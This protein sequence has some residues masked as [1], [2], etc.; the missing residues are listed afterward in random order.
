M[1]ERS[2]VEA[3]L[4]QGVGILR[5]NGVSTKSSVLQLAVEARSEARCCW[6]DRD[7]HTIRGRDA[8]V[9]PAGLDRCASLASDVRGR[10]CAHCLGLP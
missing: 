7:A 10:G 1:W 3:G 2:K 9:P 4:R 8:R 5:R 6:L